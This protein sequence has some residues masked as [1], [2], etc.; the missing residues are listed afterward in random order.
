MF[1]VNEIKWDNKTY[2]MLGTENKMWLSD[3]EKKKKE[4]IGRNCPKALKQH[5]RKFQ[6]DK[7]FIVYWRRTEK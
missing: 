1:I 6:N 5:V 2:T 4:L 7:N 3:G